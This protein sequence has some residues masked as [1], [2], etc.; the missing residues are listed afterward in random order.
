MTKKKN[1]FLA[2]FIEVAISQISPLFFQNRWQNYRLFF[3]IQNQS[4]LIEYDIIQALC[5]CNFPNR[6]RS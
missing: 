5:F 2:F 4:I 3:E 1:L 6:C